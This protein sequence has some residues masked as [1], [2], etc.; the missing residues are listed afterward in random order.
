MLYVDTQSLMERSRLKQ[1][2]SLNLRQ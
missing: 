1:S 2:A